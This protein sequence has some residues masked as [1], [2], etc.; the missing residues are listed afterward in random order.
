FDEAVISMN[1]YQGYS[2]EITR[3]ILVKLGEVWFKNEFTEDGFEQFQRQTKMF[4]GIQIRECKIRLISDCPNIDYV[5]RV[6]SLFRIELLTFIVDSDGSLE[7]AIELMSTVDDCKKNVEI[8]R[9]YATEQDLT[10]LPPLEQLSFTIRESYS[11]AREMQRFTTA[12]LNLIAIHKVVVVSNVQLQSNDMKRILE[13]ISSE[14]LERMVKLS[15]KTHIVKSWMTNFRIYPDTLIGD[16][17][18]EFTVIRKFSDDF[19]DYVWLRYH[20]CW[21]RFQIA[22][23]RPNQ[24]RHDILRNE[25]LEKTV[26]IGN[27][28]YRD[29]E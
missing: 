26:A 7:N 4:Y 15:T 20:N 28:E 29:W 18:G 5:R 25:L 22:S 23:V 17:I 12:L 8:V 13:V 1:E 11:T 27:G 19:D 6:A 10:L 14:T 16:V 9:D 24:L 3:F 2:N 21:I